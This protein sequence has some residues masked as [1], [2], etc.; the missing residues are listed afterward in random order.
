MEDC[1]GGRRVVWI[2]F[3]RDLQ[4]TELAE[5][6]FERTGGG[7]VCGEGG[8]RGERAAARTGSCA[9][10]V[11]VMFGLAKGPSA[12]RG[13]VWAV[14]VRVEFRRVT[15]KD[16]AAAL[17]AEDV[18]ALAEVAVKDESARWDPL[19]A[20]WTLDVADIGRIFF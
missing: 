13:V 20:V 4:V 9:V 15:A 12:M 14:P 3:L 2:A 1:G 7:A 17:R 5:D 10:K 16:E 19:V 11:C 18:V 8:E 6:E